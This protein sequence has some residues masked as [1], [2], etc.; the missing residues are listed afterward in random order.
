MR[1]D[2]SFI[3][4]YVISR[5]FTF[6]NQ[7]FQLRYFVLVDGELEC[8]RTTPSISTSDLESVLEGSA[9]IEGPRG[10]YLLFKDSVAPIWRRKHGLLLHVD[11]TLAEKYQADFSVALQKCW[12]NID[13]ALDVDVAVQEEYIYNG[14]V[15]PSLVY[16]IVNQD[17]FGIR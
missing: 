15:I 9:A 4:I 6:R 14:L 5:L 3:T 10:P 17:T 12:T 11:A 1:F 2:C 16:I 7:F 8:S 13:S